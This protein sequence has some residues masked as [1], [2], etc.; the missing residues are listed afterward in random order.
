METTTKQPITVTT[1]IN[2]PLEKVWKF[3][4]EP[5]H[6]TAWCSASNDWH[7]PHAENDL[8]TDGKFKT[9]MAAKDGS[10]GF[11]FEGTYTNVEEHKTIEYIM[12][13]GLKVKINFSQE[14]AS[15]TIVETFDPEDINPIDMQRDGWQSILNNFKKY[16]EAN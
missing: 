11:D 9:V 15:S 2:A 4:T 3:F 13:D 1:S 10:F 5:E 14:G 6:I 16:T 8:R 12:A 7:V